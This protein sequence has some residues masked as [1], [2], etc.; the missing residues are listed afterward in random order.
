MKLTNLCILSIGILLL[1][2]I[3]GA[4]N[5]VM[6]MNT[7]IN[8]PVLMPGDVGIITIRVVNNGDT[9]V[10]ISR[11][12]LLGGSLS[13]AS[14]S[15]LTVGWLGKGNMMDFTFTVEGG[16]EEG[17]YYP[18]FVLEYTD[19]STLRYAIPVQIDSTSLS[20]AL[21]QNPDFVSVGTT[22]QYTLMVSNPRPNGVN[23]VQVF[24]EG[25]GYEATP[26]SQFIGYLG[27]DDATSVTFNI[28]PDR[29]S[30]AQFRA[31]YRNGIN[32][33]EAVL[34]IPL[35]PT[36]NKKAAEP[37]VSNIQISQD[38]DGYRVSG[39]I[40]NAGLK[41]AKSVVIRTESPAIAR[42]PYK[43]YV[44]G[45]LDPDDFSSFEI[46]FDLASSGTVP[47][48]VE[49]KDDDGNRYISQSYV[50]ITVSPLS[51]DSSPIP[52]VGV[53]L[54]WVLVIAIA[55]V[56]IYSWRKR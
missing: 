53:L 27:S 29:I 36:D 38:G 6:V 44:V 13:V 48:V 31:I 55:A 2:G 46:T 20:L 39:D 51:D 19:S 25:V 11:A 9:G 56:I 8:P 21:L 47:L 16:S 50:D 30:T 28:T 24:P 54:V 33:H 10:M 37:M 1:V 22:T 15:Y 7:T 4:A 40:S 12:L 43:V 42:D 52:K 49:Y 26:T 32:E 45:S 17:L 3:A 41:S 35:L 5:Q 34:S 23:G 18:R 14:D